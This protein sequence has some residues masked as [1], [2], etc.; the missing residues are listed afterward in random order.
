MDKGTV[1]LK[2]HR[3][4]W[5]M[6]TEQ[7]D[8]LV[9]EDS[10]GCVHDPEKACFVLCDGLGGHGMGD[11]ASQSVLA[12][13]MSVAKAEKLDRGWIKRTVEKAQT[14]LIA[15]QKEKAASQKMKTTL[16]MLVTD[17]RK[18][19]IAHVGDSRLYLLRGGRIILQTQDHSVPQMLV[20]SGDITPEEIRDHPDRSMLMRVLGIPWEKDMLEEEKPIHIHS[21]DTFLLCSDGFWELI[22]ESDM[23]RLL[24]KSG[25]ME[26][27]LQDM[28]NVLLENGKSVNRDNCSAIAGQFIRK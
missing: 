7:G 12:S 8:R 9:N 15:L 16:V 19:R 24:R 14:D 17:G 27:W 10:I 5:A 13:I 3:I 21:G 26:A 23:E 6:Y 2:K 20:R 11:Q 22:I 28:W 25:D 4:N 18:L 1:E